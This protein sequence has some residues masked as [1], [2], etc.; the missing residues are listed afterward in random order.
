LH[1]F[2][3]KLLNLGVT[4]SEIGAFFTISMKNIDKSIDYEYNINTYMG[5]I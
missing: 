4:V 1:E 3:G 5:I 2:T